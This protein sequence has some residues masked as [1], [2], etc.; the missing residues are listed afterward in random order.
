LGETRFFSGWFAVIDR[1]R[2]GR[3]RAGLVEVE[4]VDAE[5]AEVEPVEVE[6]A[7]VEE[8]YSAGRRGC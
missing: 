8:L 4:P 3:D 7:E 2:G 1:A 5:V 6:V